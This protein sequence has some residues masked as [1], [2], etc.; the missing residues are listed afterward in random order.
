MASRSRCR[1]GRRAGEQ[2]IAV[3]PDMATKAFRASGL[4]RLALARRLGVNEKVVRRMLD[5]RHHTAANRIHK[6]LRALG[7]ELI[8]ESRAA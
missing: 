2:L 3:S 7:Q 5:P 4:S 8:V 1:V 6:A